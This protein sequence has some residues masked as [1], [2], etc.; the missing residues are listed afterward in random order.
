MEIH[1]VASFMHPGATVARKMVL[2]YCTVS[3]SLGIHFE[4]S[5]HREMDEA[6]QPEGEKVSDRWN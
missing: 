2:P 4:C 1:S 5:Y 3:S 6:V